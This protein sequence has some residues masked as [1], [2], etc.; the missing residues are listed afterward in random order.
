MRAPIMKA[1]MTS[2]KEPLEARRERNREAAR[3]IYPGGMETMASTSAR[4][5]MDVNAES[6][7]RSLGRIRDGMPRT[8]AIAA[9]ASPARPD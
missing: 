4:P 7:A 3:G 9:S 6:P 2:R 1:G 5:R 8:Q